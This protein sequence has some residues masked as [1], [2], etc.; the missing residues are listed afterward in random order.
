M[1][2]GAGYCYRQFRPQKG[3][4]CKIGVNQRVVIP[5]VIAALGKSGLCSYTAVTL[6]EQ[7]NSDAEP[8]SAFVE[9]FHTVGRLLP[10]ELW[11]VDK[12][13]HRISQGLG[14]HAVDYGALP[15]SAKQLL[16]DVFRGE[17]VSGSDCVVYGDYGRIR[18]QNHPGI[19]EIPSGKQYNVKTK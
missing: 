6:E 18:L 16:D 1:R 3:R 2:V 10:E 5:K 12:G 9:Y 7:I 4:W 8:H 11:L 14:I 15:D 13:E 19:L 17:A